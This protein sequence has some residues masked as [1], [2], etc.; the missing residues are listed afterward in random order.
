MSLA[1]YQALKQSLT[2]PRPFDHAAQEAAYQLRHAELFLMDR[3]VAILMAINIWLVFFVWDYYF[4]FQHPEIYSHAILQRI[5]GI[6]LLGLGL[7]ISGALA[8]WRDS[9]QVGHVANRWMLVIVGGSAAL[10]LA[11]IALIPPPINYQFTYFGLLLIAVFLYGA[12][13]VPAKPAMLLGVA[14]FAGMVLVEIGWG[15]HNEYFVNAAF[16]FVCIWFIGSSI[17]VRL[18]NSE[19]ANFLAM[20]RLELA[21]HELQQANEQVEK[22]RQQAVM[23]RLRADAERA[24]AEQQAQQTLIEKSRAEQAMAETLS[25]RE[26]LIR[27]M[28]DVAEE[29]NRFVRAAYHDTMQPLAAIGAFAFA[30]GK[31]LEAGDSGKAQAQIGQISLAARDIENMFRAL[32]DLF[33]LGTQPV[34]LQAVAVAPLLQEVHARFATRAQ[35]KG[36]RL[37]LRLPANPVSVHSDPAML[38]RMLEN[39]LSNAI[40]YTCQGCVLL[41][42]T[43]LG[44]T[45]RFDVIDSGIGIAAGVQGRIFEEFFQVN[46][47]GRDRSKGLGLGLSIVR[48]LEDKLPGHRLLFSSREGVGSRFCVKVPL[49]QLPGSADMVQAP[50]A[51]LD[52][53]VNSYILIVDDDYRLL[54]SMEAVL[55]AYGA[56]VRKAADL[57]TLQQLLEQAPDRA[58]NLVLTDWRLQ[59]GETGADVVTVIDRHFD[60]ATVPVVVATADIALPTLTR[61]APTYVRSKADG[62]PALLA[63][64]QEAICA[65]RAANALVD[66]AETIPNT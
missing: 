7:L 10:V 15:T 14:I 5:Q 18:E 8:S 28:G 24:R 51:T 47:P 56:R 27:A 39:L 1:L 37:Q 43:R 45:V 66:D 50:E 59:Q 31:Q 20:A 55:S 42:A 6:R 46:N 32:H 23:E 3:R 30:A 38:R 57:A 11:M 33:T 65:G 17:A 36:L 58:P 2:W 34:K 52:A 40:K 41:A 62:M 25:Q 19:R 53:L 22:Q 54:E 35:D 49:A 60:W 21:N 64:I 61:T 44:D 4:F 12:L 63:T 16:Y 48:L 13:G 26:Q 29:R 9:F